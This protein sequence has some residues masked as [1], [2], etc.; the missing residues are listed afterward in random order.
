MPIFRKKLKSMKNMHSDF[1]TQ[2]SLSSS[3]TYIDFELPSPIPKISVS[4]NNQK[5]IN[6][7]SFNEI[8]VESKYLSCSRDN[9]FSSINQQKNNF[10]INNSKLSKSQFIIKKNKLDV[11]IDNVFSRQQAFKLNGGLNDKF[12]N[13]KIEHKSVKAD[14]INLPLISMKHSDS[15]YYTLDTSEEDAEK[16]FINDE[17]YF[18]S[19]SFSNQPKLNTYY[20]FNKYKE[21]EEMCDFRLPKTSYDAKSF[22]YQKNKNSLLDDSIVWSK[23]KRTIAKV[24]EIRKLK[25]NQ[26]EV[27]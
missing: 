6:V 21:R 26:K 15:T 7:K 24:Y 9:F 27:F 17:S 10:P 3:S 20:N 22:N 13:E 8:A 4:L 18:K 1:Q 19:D 2:A 11:P 12:K 23:Y 14:Q 5:N 16:L 25:E